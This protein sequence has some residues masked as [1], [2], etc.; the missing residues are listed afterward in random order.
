MTTKNDTEPTEDERRR[1]GYWWEAHGA[2]DDPGERNGYAHG[3]AA[4]RAELAELKQL[5]GGEF[6]EAS[7]DKALTEARAERDALREA[8]AE[9]VG[10]VDECAAECDALREALRETL[11]WLPKDSQAAEKIRKVLEVAP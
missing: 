4:N 7:K 2:V 11:S 8:L 9:T 6:L 5:V 10:L 3:L 1:A